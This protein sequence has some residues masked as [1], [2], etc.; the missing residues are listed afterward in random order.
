MRTGRWHVR[1]EI[2]RSKGRGRQWR[3]DVVLE[4]HGSL[5]EAHD[6]PPTGRRTDD[7]VFLIPGAAGSTV[8]H[9]TPRGHVCHVSGLSIMAL[10]PGE[11]D[12]RVEAA[13]PVLNVL[14]YG[15]DDIVHCKLCGEDERAVAALGARNV[16]YTGGDLELTC[17]NPHWEFLLEI[18]PDRLPELAAEAHE[19]IAPTSGQFRAKQDPAMNVPADLT[20]RHLRFGTPDPLYVQGLAIAMTARALSDAA[21]GGDLSSVSAI[22]TDARI[23]RAVDYIEA[24]L[25]DELSVAAVA[26]VAAMSPS[27]FQTSFRAVMGVPVF[28]YVRERRLK[29]ARILLSDRRLSLAQIAHAC[30][31]A[32]AAH[33]SRSFKARYGASPSQVR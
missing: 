27:W 19:G 20:I 5:E 29:R 18:D 8:D 15:A 10:P 11:V 31:F 28:A 4:A 7:Y 1:P 25:A 16:L 32:D 2:E 14:P 6:D 9:L 22:G 12:I 23:A 26:S 13:T 33:L 21:P 17:S 30:G 24:H 3:L